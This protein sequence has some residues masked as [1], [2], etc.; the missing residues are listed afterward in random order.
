V[1]I[2]L[3]LQTRGLRGVLLAVVLLV[4]L[5]GI[6]VAAAWFNLAN[7]PEPLTMAAQRQ[8]KPW[9]DK[10][11]LRVL[12]L[13]V[14]GLPVIASHR[15]ERMAAI[16]AMIAELDVDLVGLQEAFVA[17]DRQILIQQLAQRF[18]Y[19]KYFDSGLAGSGLFT[20]SRYP[21]S[22]AAFRRFPE[23]GKWFKFYHGDW[24]AGKGVGL[25]RVEIKPGVLLDFHN[26]HLQ[27]EYAQTG[28]SANEYLE[29]RTA[30]MMEISAF[31]QTHHSAAIPAL[32]VGDLNSRKKD[33]AYEAGVRAGPLIDL[34]LM[35]SGIDH[36]KARA[37]G[38]FDFRVIESWEIDRW[39]KVDGGPV[40]LSDHYGYLSSIVISVRD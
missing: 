9:P 21:I 12:T 26:S 27:A 25:V 36:I 15:A 39:T 11:A 18:R 19:H 33:P 6:I 17:E 7:N 37:H 3:E 4:V 14:Q 38:S 5:A 35:D 2:F 31:M 8:A 20:L 28:P 13:N 22:T 10:M 23:G 29:V 1:D 34:T 24:W 30:Q 40:A 32:L 16:A